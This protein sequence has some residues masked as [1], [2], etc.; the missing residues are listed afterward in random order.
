VYLLFGGKPLLFRRRGDLLTGDRLTRLAHHG[1]H[2]LFIPSE[3]RHLYLESLKDIFRDPDAGTDVKSK[4]IKETAFVHI[5]DLFTK[6][7]IQPVVDE[8]KATI[9]DLVAFVSTDIHAVSSL[10]R[11][12]AHDYYTYN[13]SVD[14]AVYSIVLAKK[15]FGEDRNIL[16]AAGIA[17]LLHDIGKRRIDLALIN[18]STP[19]TPEEWAEI[20]RHPSYGLE[21]LKDLSTIPED[22]KAVVHQHHENYDG[23]GYP[24]GRRG[25]DIARLARVVS[26]ADVFDALTT[27]RSYHKAIPPTDALNMMFGMQPGKFDPQIF[28]AFNKNFDRKKPELILAQKF[29]PCSPAELPTL[30][31]PKK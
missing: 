22:S 28:S 18:K 14:V 10:M 26:I 7:D 24:D 1:L 13:H 27:D 9:N 21:I 17:G 6:Q 19:L 4:F 29:D 20:R 31:N 15:I 23:T 16:M 3:Q 25:D 11:L 5:H 30:V 8:A 2:Q 12:S